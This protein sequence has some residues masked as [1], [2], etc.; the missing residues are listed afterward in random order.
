MSEYLIVCTTLGHFLVF[1][2]SHDNSEYQN[3]FPTEQLLSK[4]L[5]L[6]P[7]FQEDRS[8]M[9]EV[10]GRPTISSPLFFRFPP[11]LFVYRLH[12]RYGT[13]DLRNDIYE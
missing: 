3:F 1:G 9:V 12:S 13:G 11:A 10:L 4:I 7:Y 6:P 8:V 5:G 2:S